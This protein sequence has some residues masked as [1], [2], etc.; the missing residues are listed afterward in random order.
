MENN[1]QPIFTPENHSEIPLAPI[2]KPGFSLKNLTKNTKIILISIA[3]LFAVGL[4]AL[5]VILILNSR[6]TATLEISVAPASA[7]IKINGNSMRNGQYHVEPGSYEAE[8]TADGFEPYSGK[9]ELNAGDTN[10][11]FIVLFPTDE[12][13]DYYDAHPE[14]DALAEYTTNRAIFLAEEATHTDPI[15]QFTPYHSEDNTFMIDPTITEEGNLVVQLTLTSCFPTRQDEAKKSIE[16]W[17]TKNSLSL[18]SY[19][20]FYVIP[21]C[22]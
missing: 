11:F 6:K 9:I 15:W 17:F 8:I 19:D 4:I 2:K 12:T 5:V 16:D 22:N 13:S 21:T 18:D 10:G 14:D 7:T 20:Y 1:F 3:S